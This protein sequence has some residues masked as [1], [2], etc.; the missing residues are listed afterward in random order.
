MFKNILVKTS[1]ALSLVL[2][3]NINSIAME[4]IEEINPSL[5]SRFE[6]TAEA[7]ASE[8]KSIEAREPPEQKN[9]RVKIMQEFAKDK[10]NMDLLVETAK[11]Y[12]EEMKQGVVLSVCLALNWSEQSKQKEYA[13]RLIDF[14]HEVI[15]RNNTLLESA[16]E[17]FCFYSVTC[18]AVGHNRGRIFVLP[19]DERE[20]L[21]RE[22]YEGFKKCIRLSENQSIPDKEGALAGA[23]YYLYVYGY[24]NKFY[25]DCIDYVKNFLLLNPIA[26][27]LKSDDDSDALMLFHMQNELAFCYH[28]C[29]RCE[30]ALEAYEKAIYYECFKADGFNYKGDLSLSLHKILWNINSLYQKLNY[31]NYR[32]RIEALMQKRNKILMSYAV[33]RIRLVK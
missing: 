16:Y 18:E 2:F 30:D 8:D 20:E 12:A 25:E 9:L 1:I 14:L 26:R 15:N 32:E 3:P 27:M 4:P 28:Y 13:M 22:T 19:K 31:S 29:N 17:C 6:A 5:E 24:E 23:F 10:P 11:Q 7:T 21:E 33:E